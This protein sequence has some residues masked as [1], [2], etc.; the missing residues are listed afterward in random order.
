MKC[1][2]I[3]RQGHRAGFSLVEV[4]LA[5]TVL[6]MLARMLIESS[7]SMSRMTSSGSVQALLQEQGEKALAA[8][9]KDL[10]RSGSVTLNGADYPY[11]FDDGIADPPF[12]AH[13]HQVCDQ[14]AD[15]G[16]SD[17][18]TMREIVLVKPADLDNNSI[19]DLDMDGNGWP[20]FDGDH[21]GVASE[22]QADYAGVDWDPNANSIDVETGVVWSLDEI[23]YVTVTHP[24]G[25]NYLERRINADPTTARRVARDI[26]LV[27]FD[28]WESS[29][30][31]IA[32]NSVRV[33]IFLRRRTENGALYRYSVE[34]VVKLRN[35]KEAG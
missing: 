24:D 4:M 25:I 28:T 29:G 2:Q 15:Q 11:V 34:A 17:F 6:M 16:D 9:V 20:E 10:R 19:P 14:E 30:Y 35:T 33:R 18:G 7:V 1:L 5:A 27:Q 26:E 3:Q 8:I 23:S 12:K 32:M 13:T 31:T 22:S 21:D